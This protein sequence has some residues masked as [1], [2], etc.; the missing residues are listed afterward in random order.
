MGVLVAPTIS[1]SCRESIDCLLAD[2][3]WRL[4]LRLVHRRRLDMELEAVPEILECIA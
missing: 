3:D 4:A 2:F 1:W